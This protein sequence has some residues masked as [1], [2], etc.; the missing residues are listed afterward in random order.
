MFVCCFQQKCHL[1][2]LLSRVF[3]VRLLSRWEY[4]INNVV[5]WLERSNLTQILSKISWS[6]NIMEKYLTKEHDGETFKN[7]KWT[8]WKSGETDKR[9]DVQSLITVKNLYDFLA[10]PRPFVRNIL[11]VQLHTLHTSSTATVLYV[12][13]V[14][15]VGQNHELQNK[16]VCLLDTWEYS[17]LKSIYKSW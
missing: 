6:S 17:N 4:L 5:F 14:N 12:K 8:S 3:I 16:L 7:D 13:K 10:I 1:V 9:L 11:G 2:R 15:M